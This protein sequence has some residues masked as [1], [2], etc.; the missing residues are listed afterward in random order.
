M[1]LIQI[2]YLLAFLSCKSQVKSESINNINMET[3]D[4]EKYRKN[5]TNNGYIFHEDNEKIR[6]VESEDKTFWEERS[7]EKTGIRIYKE[8]HKNSKLKSI[9]KSFYSIKFGFKKEYDEQGKL[10]RETN[11]DLPYK[12]TIEDLAT[13]MNNQY[14]IDIYN[15]KQIHSINRYEEK[16]H[17]KIPLYEVWSY[18]K[19]NP[20]KLTCYIINGT[21]GETIYEDERF[22]EGK[23]GSL[24]DQ[25]L[26]TKN[27]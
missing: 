22:I 16:K 25:Y 1:R 24:L 8:F 13:K 26:K 12:Y 2:I 5:K 4:I 15:I 14:Q 23:Q 3:I 17:L 9:L 10:I 11:Y 18:H 20:L 7:N 21:T 19:T 27:K 6:Q